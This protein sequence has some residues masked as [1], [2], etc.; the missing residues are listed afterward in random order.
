MHGTLITITRDGNDG[1]KY[2]LVKQHCFI[3]SSDSC[4]IQVKN[5]SVSEKHC[6]VTAFI[7]GYVTL[8]N[9]NED[10]STF[11][12]GIA[13][14]ENSYHLKH[15]DIVTVADRSFRWE[16]PESSKQMVLEIMDVSSSASRKRKYECLLPDRLVAVVSP[17]PH[18]SNYNEQM[19]KRR[20]TVIGSEDLQNSFSLPAVTKKSSKVFANKRPS[21]PATVLHSVN[22]KKKRSFIRQTVAL[23]NYNSSK[24]FLVNDDATQV[25]F[26][27]CSALGSTS[28]TLSG[29][30]TI[31]ST[32]KKT[33]EKKNPSA[34]NKSVDK[35]TSASD[36][37]QSSVSVKST[38]HIL[39]GTGYK[40]P[41]LVTNSLRKP[42]KLIS[43]RNNASA[44]SSSKRYSKPKFI[45]KKSK[46]NS[47]VKKITLKTKITPPKKNIVDKS[48]SAVMSSNSKIPVR[49]KMVGMTTSGSFRISSGKKQLYDFKSKTPSKINKTPKRTKKKDKTDY[50]KQSTSMETFSPL[51]KELTPSP[52]KKKTERQCIKPSISFVSESKSQQSSLK[53]TQHE[54]HDG[55]KI[56]S[57]KNKT[58]SFLQSMSKSITQSSSSLSYVSLE[59]KHLTK[60][61]RKSSNRN[62][63]RELN[64]S[65]EELSNENINSY[66]DIM[67]PRNSCSLELQLT[68]CDLEK[69]IPNR[70]DTINARKSG[71]RDSSL[72]SL[73][74][75]LQSVNKFSPKHKNV[76]S[77][78]Q[79][80][81]RKDE[82][83]DQSKKGSSSIS[84]NSVSLS[85]AYK[86]TPKRGNL[87]SRNQTPVSHGEMDDQSRICSSSVSNNSVLL[88]EAGKFTPKKGNLRSRNQTPVNLG[89]MD[90]QSRRGS[91][92]ISNNSIILP[93]GNK[94]TP[95][96]GNLRSRNQTP[97]GHGEMDDQSR[98]SLSV[99]N[100]S[101]LQPE[102]GK[103]IPKKGNLRSRNQTPINQGEMET[104]PRRGSSS[105]SNNSI[106]LPEGNK[107]TPKKGNL[108]SRN[109]TPISH[110]E[111]DDQSRIS[112]SVSNNSVLLPEAGKFTPKKG[113]L[114]SRNQTPINQGEM[115]TQPKRGSSSI[116]NNSIMLPEGDKL[117]PKRGNLRSRNQTPV[118]Q[119][120]MDFQS[121]KGSSSVSNN[122]VILSVAYTFTPK[123]GNLRSRNQTPVSHGQMDNQS[124]RGSSSIS[125]NSVVLPEG[126]KLT[127]KR[128]NLQS[129][130][131]TPVNHGEM[132]VQSRGGLSS[133]S[134]DSFI[135]PEAHKFTPK[136]RNLPS[137]NQTPVNQS[138][139]TARSR[140]G[141]SSVSNDSDILPETD[142]FTPKIKNLRSRNRMP[143]SHE[144]DVQSRSSSLLS[145]CFILSDANKFT[146]KR[147]SLYS[148]N[149]TFTP[150]GQVGIDIH[151]LGAV[152]NK[153]N[154]N[155]SQSVIDQIETDVK[156]EFIDELSISVN[157]IL[158]SNEKHLHKQGGRKSYS[159]L[160]EVSPSSIMNSSLMTT[161]ATELETNDQ[162][163]QN[164]L[165]NENIKSDSVS[166]PLNENITLRKKR[167]NVNYCVTAKKL[168]SQRR[169][170]NSKITVPFSD[171]KGVIRRKNIRAI[172]HFER[173]SLPPQCN[174]NPLI[175]QFENTAVGKRAS[176]L[177]H[178][179]VIGKRH[180][181][182]GPINFA[183]ISETTV[184]HHNDFKRIRS[185]SKGLSPSFQS[186]QSPKTHGSSIKDKGNN[187]GS[188][189]NSTNSCKVSI[190]PRF[191]SA[192]RSS[193][194]SV[195]SENSVSLQK[196]TQ[197]NQE[198][199]L[200]DEMLAKS[201]LVS[202]PSKSINIGLPVQE[203]STRKARSAHKHFPEVDTSVSKS[204]HSTE[205]KAEKAAKR[206][207]SETPK[208]PDKKKMA[209]LLVCHLRS[210]SSV[211]K[212]PLYSDI[213][214]SKLSLP[215]AMS[216]R[217]V[218]K[219][220]LRKSN[221]CQITDNYNEKLLSSARA[222]KTIKLS[223]SSENIKIADIDNFN[224]NPTRSGNQKNENEFSLNLHGR[225]PRKSALMSAQ[226]SSKKN[227]KVNFQLNSNQ[228]STPKQDTSFS[229]RS[230]L[231]GKSSS[232][233]KES[234]S[235][236]K[237]SRKFLEA[238]E[239]SSD[240]TKPDSSENSQK[241]RKS[242]RKRKLCYQLADSKDT[243][244]VSVITSHTKKRTLQK[245][246]SDGLELSG[247]VKNLLPFKNGSSKKNVKSEQELFDSNKTR[248]LSN[249]TL[250][251]SSLDLL[252]KSE[253][254]TTNSFKTP[255]GSVVDSEGSE[256]SFKLQFATPTDTSQT[257]YASCALDNSFVRQDLLNSI[258]KSDNKRQS[259][260]LESLEP[261]SAESSITKRAKKSVSFVEKS[262]N[263]SNS[264]FD[265]T[266]EQTQAN[267]SK[268][269]I[270]SPLSTGSNRKK[271]NS[272]DSFNI[273]K[274]ETVI[275][276][277]SPATSYVNVTG[278]K[279]ILRTPK[280]PKSSSFYMEGV[281][282]LLKTPKSPKSS[283]LNVE[284]VKR[285]MRTPKS[286]KS[287]YLNVEGVKRLGRTP[288]SP[289]S[290]YLDVE[291]VKRLLRT[292]KS[293][294]SSYLNVEGVKRIFE[295]PEKPGPSYNDVNVKKCD[296][297]N[298][299]KSPN[300]PESFK[301]TL[302]DTK[303]FSEITE[304]ELK[305]VAISLPRTRASRNS[306][307]SGSSVASSEKSISK[308]PRRSRGFKAEVSLPWVSYSEKK[309]HGISFDEQLV[310]ISNCVSD[311]STLQTPSNI[312][313]SIFVSP[314][315]GNSSIQQTSDDL[316]IISD[317][318]V[319][320]K[321]RKSN[322]LDV[323]GIKRLARTPRKSNSAEIEGIKQ[324]F[325][326][327]PVPDYTDV[328]G[329]KRLFGEDEKRSYLDVTGVRNALKDVQSPSVTGVSLLFSS[330]NLPST[331]AKENSDELEHKFNLPKGTTT[332][333]QQKNSITS[334]ESQTMFNN[335]DVDNIKLEPTY[336]RGV[337]DT[338]SEHTSSLSTQSKKQN[339]HFKNNEVQSVSSVNEI[340]PKNLKRM[341]RN[342][343]R[344]SQSASK[345][346]ST[347]ELVKSNVLNQNLTNASLNGK[348]SSKKTQ[349]FV[350]VISEESEVNESNISPL[351]TRSR[352]TAVVKML[353]SRAV[354]VE[355]KKIA[356]V[357]LQKSKRNLEEKEPESVI[358]TNSP[359]IFK[360]RR[361]RKVKNSNALENKSSHL[362]KKTVLV[363]P[364]A[365]NSNL[366]KDVI[367]TKIA[368]NTGAKRK[369]VKRKL[370]SDLQQIT[371]VKESIPE[372]TVVRKSKRLKGERPS[373]ASISSN[374]LKT[375]NSRP[376]LLANKKKVQFKPAKSDVG[377]EHKKRGT[378]GK[379]TKK[380]DSSALLEDT[381]VEVKNPR[382]RALSKKSVKPESPEKEKKITSG[383]Q[384]K[385]SPMAKGKVRIMG[386]NKTTAN[387][388]EEPKAETKRKKAGANEQIGLSAVVEENAGGSK[389][390]KQ[391]GARKKIT[392]QKSGAEFPVISLRT[393]SVVKK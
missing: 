203:I 68:K 341:T 186:I 323:K 313:T 48:S 342:N 26:G 71:R 381:F 393:R 144:M 361:G 167:N 377:S 126:N 13:V 288:K 372:L 190:S 79:T 219:Q 233:R 160:D 282:R 150:N 92:S 116:A 200:S 294:K 1:G 41:T 76:Q 99:S 211:K 230:S 142:K 229:L 315:S 314:L 172:K 73:S 95:K 224:L 369:E 232:N 124:R 215:A 164:V 336:F 252:G 299:T 392:D 346:I 198:S 9:L 40:I 2:P 221:L 355:K 289:K 5:S 24:K 366:E 159:F 169:S 54:I 47:A 243:F 354:K 358:C 166:L 20:R 102:A 244:A 239:L 56:L 90:T 390:K 14:G 183:N 277:K 362:E 155:L 259:K 301:G 177:S 120:E 12:N 19:T 161:I 174:Q 279:K 51:A 128:G 391:K 157:N 271:S 268:S 251:N 135:L 131:Q 143:V 59:E 168:T 242:A 209:A 46:L 163:S 32:S 115:D 380:E 267:I 199:G 37:Q 55:F 360:A 304:L 184:N 185:I 139:M 173:N 338:G 303:G 278:V 194:T 153:R 317:K 328:I 64:C 8:Q 335:S 280:S 272:S 291:G 134:N 241:I 205:Y 154:S 266:T 57:G 87:L 10:N 191:K 123:R 283:Y 357:G 326:V 171:S 250:L 141:S 363:S 117:T 334:P 101:V 327:S 228:L 4:D 225:Q 86:F 253:D 293:P 374:D 178:K 237:P 307:L 295:T 67:S 38:S 195:F 260:K 309:T 350:Q 114:R 345:Q 331:Y 261:R 53:K 152:S 332:R 207:K 364:S 176:F 356:N 255:D 216:S 204:K 192:S 210:R 310:N 284:G 180:S 270:I 197:K 324:I 275:S 347:D 66:K 344:E 312:S 236:V 113:N 84:N 208:S 373:F 15:K 70:S 97:I 148:R 262:E 105:I 103:F 223:D 61:A 240:S 58:E 306:V 27:N 35:S 33:I 322:H 351:R 137:G 147:K 231:A 119:D 248:S 213:V 281:K 22:R 88:P 246:S 78:N 352:K 238:L 156:N 72:Q 234:R 188:A 235:I 28:K 220:K 298:Y 348:C 276:P 206:L 108:R 31:I 133:I 226:K 140:S 365:S 269:I 319:T 202:S 43:P 320:P 330:T 3:G 29:N 217:I 130:N 321:N 36:I 227:L 21:F 189:L 74:I 127:P 17:Q 287:S 254:S 89:E 100:N 83:D 305:P 201:I 93:E 11:V 42:E 333:F 94:L 125:N 375:S 60:S 308:S 316:D 325:Q 98:I 265:F 214:K 290:S 85:E 6:L 311:F 82:M 25:N 175:N 138:E 370:K 162:A 75:M 273:R 274:V 257:T 386:H 63:L 49:S 382:K 121:R 110:G 111:M 39:S 104:Q 292:P 349:Q 212:K 91:S 151:T 329:V 81:V 158:Q 359:I 146:P 193:V 129:R 247:L 367:D 118:S 170:V 388:L 80:P 44:K 371:E 249:S 245:R 7:H 77:R 264:M 112:S 52:C 337:C 385:T 122:S 285:L 263:V 340:S 296:V 387:T 389:N 145:N 45:L 379:V 30:A 384:K 376:S 16:Y 106:I 50:E 353:K 222:M 165:S 297:H 339:K 343:A 179:T 182:N 34:L 256:Q 218:H 149:H 18:G 107:L 109:Q 69:S 23:P 187:F 62:M 181:S 65:Q 318:K 368:K 378:K 383:K 258:K 286:P 196:T 132:D 300:T 96:R 302:E 136:R